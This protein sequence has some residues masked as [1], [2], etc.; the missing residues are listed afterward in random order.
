MAKNSTVGNVVTDGSLGSR[1]DLCVAGSLGN[2]YRLRERLDGG[3]HGILY[4]AEQVNHDGREVVIKILRDALLGDPEAVGRFWREAYLGGLICHPNTVSIMESGHTDDGRMFVVMESLRGRTLKALIAEGVPLSL[5]RTLCIMAQVL[6]GLEAIHRARV[7]HSDIKSRSIF[8]TED[9]EERAV[10][11]DFGLARLLHGKPAGEQPKR[12][13]SGE[14]DR[15]QCLE[16]CVGELIRNARFGVARATHGHNLP[17]RGTPGYIAPEVILGE[18]PTYSSDIY[19]AGILLYKML[20]GAT[21]FSARRP[22]GILQQQLDGN[23][24]LPTRPHYA[25]RALHLQT[26]LSRATAGKPADRFG[27]AREFRQAVL[28]LAMPGQFGSDRRV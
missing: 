24:R 19:A 12:G 9:G 4:R 5:A 17:I 16:P 22:I 18:K 11:L 10:I 20:V 25:M 13:C 28:S 14:V 15:C 26:M 2:R 8:I 27:S 23:I 6:A 3:A 21:P 1:L 7:A